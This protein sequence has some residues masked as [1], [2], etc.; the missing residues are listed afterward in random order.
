MPMNIGATTSDTSSVTS[1]VQQAPGLGKDDFLKLLVGQ[2]RNQNPM[3]PTGSQD[4]IQQMTMFSTLEQVT[5]MAAAGQ[6]TE[7]ALATQ[8]A[9]DLIGRNVTYVKADGLTAQGVVERVSFADG[10][11]QLTIGGET[12][13]EP[14]AVTEVS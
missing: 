8:Q 1:A 2:L 4:F 10:I 11:A 5:N 12:G 14:G 7:G 3:D 13:I 9:V 6:R